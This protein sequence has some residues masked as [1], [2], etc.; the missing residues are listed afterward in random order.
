MLSQADELIQLLGHLLGTK[1]QEFDQPTP[2]P[3]LDGRPLHIRF[4]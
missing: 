3:W 2:M 4:S 1:H